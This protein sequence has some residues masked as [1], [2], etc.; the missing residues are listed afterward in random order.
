[1]YIK[2]FLSSFEIFKELGEF[3]TDELMINLCRELTYLHKQKDEV[4]FYEGDIGKK[5][6]IIIDGEVE[7][8]EERITKDS[9][10]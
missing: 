6:Y 2:K 4:I 7:V 8:L 9:A 3:L 1:M 5:F 10:R